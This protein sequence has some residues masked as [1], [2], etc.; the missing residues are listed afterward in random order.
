MPEHPTHAKTLPSEDEP[1]AIR[2]PHLLPATYRVW[3]LDGVGSVSI[4]T[5]TATNSWA[6]A[7]ACRASRV[8]ATVTLSPCPVQ[9]FISGVLCSCSALL[10][11]SSSPLE[12]Y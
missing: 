12:P 1:L 6:H 10:L 9:P 4:P 5:S 7:V 3:L 2:A 8:L 11:C